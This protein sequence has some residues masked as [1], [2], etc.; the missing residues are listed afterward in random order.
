MAS[1]NGPDLFDMYFKLWE[2]TEPPINLQ[3]WSL[4]GTL[5]AW[6]GRQ[7]W[8]PFSNTRIN[9][10]Q[11]IMFVGDPGCRK[12][13]AI[14]QAVGLITE[15]GYDTIAA[16][17][18]SKEGFLMS[19][20]GQEYQEKLNNHRGRKA[21]D[22][23]E[24]VDV[25]GVDDKMP[26]EMFVT[27]DEFN[28]FMGDSNVEF[29]TLLGRFWDWHDEH[30]PYRYVL[31]NSKPLVVYQPTVSILSGNTPSNFAKCFPPD[32]IGQGFMSRLIL[33]RGEASGKKF[34][35]PP[36]PDQR[37]K[38]EVLAR[39]LDIKQRVIGPMTLTE[40]AKHMRGM[41]YRTWPELEDTRFK[42]YST[43]RYMH[44]MKLTIIMAASRASLLVEAE[45]VL[46]ANTLLTYT[47]SLMPKAMGEVG[48][49]KASKAADKI[50]QVL[51]EAREPKTVSD[52]FK[53]VRSDVEKI[54]DVA[55]LVASL[56]A[57]DKIQLTTTIDKKQ[58]Y[59]AKQ[60]GVS[61]KALYYDKAYLAG[62]E[63][64]R[65]HS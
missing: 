12:T 61:R 4:I 55:Q 65:E 59:L 43:R 35:D 10:N 57:A 58:G 3:R 60:Q 34:D 11:F 24:S 8:I 26:K 53:V 44:L 7:C 2:N 6:L 19:L 15:L 41:I 40:E 29:Q 64:P 38:D 50:M 20:A 45:D 46:R 52:L 9:P 54:A 13:T 31:R 23:L 63:L 27:A 37:L 36:P 39:L 33:V 28:D 56:Q 22:I 14:K 62:K 42:H 32:S 16:D 47:E 5:G 18:T 25:L 51:Y 21:E 48:A 17:K 30:I 49:S 1:Q